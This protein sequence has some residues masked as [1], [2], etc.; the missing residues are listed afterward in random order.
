MDQVQYEC[1]SMP[2][3]KISV[4]DKYDRKAREIVGAILARPRAIGGVEI[5]EKN[6]EYLKDHYR[7]RAVPQNSHKDICAMKVL[8][9]RRLDYQE[10]FYATLPDGIL[11]HWR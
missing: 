6:P 8:C 1:K 7:L 5:A 2:G 10:F 4:P 3:V 9:R 11:R